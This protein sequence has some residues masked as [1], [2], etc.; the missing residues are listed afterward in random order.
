MVKALL[1]AFLAHM[2]IMLY[3]CQSQICLKTLPFF[4]Y[5]WMM[6]KSTSLIIFISALP[7]CS[8]YTPGENS[9]LWM[10]LAFIVENN[11]LHSSEEILQ[12]HH[13]YESF[14]WQPSCIDDCHQ[15]EDCIASS[16]IKL[17]SFW[18]LPTPMMF[19][20]WLLTL[21]QGHHLWC[22]PV[23]HFLLTSPI[24]GLVSWSFWVK[25]L[26]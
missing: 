19:W 9:N 16:E 4:V 1:S 15:N 12:K 17:C 23:L 5:I 24:L 14:C 6:E 3:P 26:S 22:P 21:M 25:S 2:K 20:V 13:E 7:V 10:F 18:I 11:A 8:A